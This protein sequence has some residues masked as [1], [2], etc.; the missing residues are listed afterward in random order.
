MERPECANAPTLLDGYDTNTQN[1]FLCAQDRAA[2][3][4]RGTEI[5]VLAAMDP[6]NLSG[7]FADDLCDCLSADDTYV[8]LRNAIRERLQAAFADIVNRRQNL[9]RNS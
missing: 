1:A 8:F 3:K 5:I 6:N 7:P 4:S 2:V 9:Q